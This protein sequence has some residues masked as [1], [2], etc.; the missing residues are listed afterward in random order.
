MRTV[1]FVSLMC[2]ALTGARAGEESVTFSEQNYTNGAAVESYLGSAFSITFDKGSNSNAPKYYDL[3]SAIRCYGGNTFTVTSN[4]TITDITLTFG[5]GDGTN[6]ITTDVGTYD[7]GSWTGSATEVTFT[8]GGTR[9][10]RRIASVTVTYNTSSSTPE[11]VAKPTFTPA[12]GTYLEAQSVT[13]GCMTN[14]ATIY[15]TLDGSDPTT[16]SNVYSNAIP[17]SKTTI[18]KAIAVK[19]G[20]DNSSVASGEYIIRSLGH[21]GTKSNPYTVADARIAIDANTGLTN[22]YATGIISQ[23][24]TYNSSYNSITYWISDDGTTANQLQVYSGKGLDNTNFTSKDEIEVGATV[25]VYGT[26]KKYGSTYEFEQNNYLTSYKAPAG[27]DDDPFVNDDPNAEIGD[28]VLSA[29]IVD[30]VRQVPT[31]GT[32]GFT[33]NTVGY[34]YH[35][36]S[37]KFFAESSIGTQASI[38]ETGILVKFTESSTAYLLNSYSQNSSDGA[39][40][41]HAYYASETALTLDGKNP[42]HRRFAIV[43]NGNGTF[44]LTPWASDSEYDI[45]SGSFFV[46]LAKSNSSSNTALSPFLLPDEGDV[47]W[48][49]VTKAQYKSYVLSLELYNKAQ[50]LKALIDQIE[51]LN[52]DASSVKNVYL[53]ADA[54]K[55]EIEEAIT[56][57]EALYQLAIKNKP[58]YVQPLLEEA[59]SEMQAYS[60][61]LMGKTEFA[62][63]T[64]ALADAQ[65][66]IDSQIGV[67][68]TEALNN[69]NS[70]K[71]TVVA[72]VNQFQSEGVETSLAN[73][74]NVLSTAPANSTV[75]PSDVSGVYNGISYIAEQANGRNEPSYNTEGGDLRIYANGAFTITSNAGNISSVVFNLSY[76]GVR[77]LAAITA[78]TGTVSKQAAGDQTVTWT[79]NATSITFTVSD[80]AEFGTDGSERAGQFDFTDFIVTTVGLAKYYVVTK[81]SITALVES[82]EG[83]TGY[84]TSE[85]SQ[86]KA[87][88]STAANDYYT[89][90]AAYQKLETAVGKLQQLVSEKASQTTIEAAQELMNRAVEGYNSCTLN[91]QEANELTTS[92]DNQKSTLQSSIEKYTNL[93]TALEQLRSE[94]DE[95]N[96]V[97]TAVREASHTLYD[98]TSQAYEDGS[99]IDSQ[100]DAKIVELNNSYNMLH[101]YANYYQRLDQAISSLEAVVT[102]KAMQSL[103]DEATTVISEARVG[104]EQGSILLDEINSSVEIMNTL[105]DDIFTSATQYANLATAITKLQN[106]INEVSG[107]TAHVSQSAVTRANLRLTQTTNQYEAGTITDD[108]IPAR[109]TTIDEMC[110]TLTRSVRL[111]NQFNEALAALKAE[112]DKEQKLSAATYSAAETLYNVNNRAYEEG[113][114]EDDNI[115]EVVGQM[116]DAVTSLQNSSALY[117]QL[118]G[119]IPA[120]QTAVTKKA[121]QTL[122]DEANDLLTTTQGDYAVGTINDED[123]AERISGM[124]A[125]ENSIDASATQYA[126][127]A[128]AITKLQDAINEVSGETAHVSQSALTRANLRLTQTTNQYE[129]GTITDDDIPARITTIDEMCETL[130]RSVRLYNQFNEALAALKAELDKEQKLSAATYSSAEALYKANNT[131]YDEGSIEDDNIEEEVGK[132]QDAVTSLQNSA[133]LYTQLVEAIP[134]LQTAVTKKAMQTLLNEANDLLTTTQGDYAV[135]TINDEEIAE[136]IS[137][138]EVIESSIDVSATHY[139]NLATAITLLQEAVEEVSG[140]TAHVSQS[141]LTRANMRLT[142]TT[143]QY[144]AGSIADEDIP[145]RITTIDDLCET[146]TRSVRLY[147]QFNE[148]LAALKAEL[149]KEQKLSAAT[150]SAAETLFNDNNT[151]YEEGSKDDD[152]IPDAISLLNAAVTNLQNSTTLY[153]QLNA[154]IPALEEAVQKKAVQSLMNEAQELLTEV[155]VGYTDATIT[156]ADVPTYINRM[157]TIETSIAASSEAYKNLNSAIVA[158]ETAVSTAEGN[159]TSNMYDAASSMLTE[160]QNKYEQGTIADADIP[161]KVTGLSNAA[162][163]IIAAKDMNAKVQTCTE[164]LTELNNAIGEAEELLTQAKNDVMACYIESAK[165]IEI[166]A[167]LES[168]TSDLSTLMSERDNITTRLATDKQVH[169]TAEGDMTISYAT[170]LQA[171]NTDLSD[172]RL[173]MDEKLSELNSMI[174]YLNREPLASITTSSNIV[175]LKGEYGTFCSVI[176]LDFTDVEGLQ[177][178]IVTAYIPAEGKIILT[179]VYNVPAGTGLV[180]HGTPNGRY[181]IPEGDGSAVL[182][183][184]LVGTKRSKVLSVEEDEKTNCILADGSYGL[185]FYPTSGGI[186]AAGKAYLPL[187]TSAIYQQNGVKCF[188]LVFDNATDIRDVMNTGQQ[189]VW[190]TIDGKILQQ[191]PRTKGIYVNNGKQV[192]IK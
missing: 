189:D 27:E 38:S 188:T 124:E 18:V 158:M 69:L 57:A 28:V 126:I 55:T 25:V 61:S 98:E 9:N 170:A 72:S 171:S 106:A 123:I 99:I 166:E 62:A 107:E 4:Y 29:P 12:S 53:N 180:V 168:Y 190:Y 60:T 143:N 70:V 73:L 41:Y 42:A 185:G 35:V 34:L 104:Y 1:L 91:N 11:V 120:L 160:A 142:Q 89:S 77:R 68:M 46:G 30:D 136:R 157:E 179:R 58:E 134:A 119:A 122:L 130:T 82:I 178:Y 103:I 22:V 101:N 17:V 148:A 140:E 145:A 159:V 109:I 79:G 10:N 118:A 165:K 5:T 40:W 151:A 85:I 169:A 23:V 15:Y 2:T 183:N 141:A 26:L 161:A 138:M 150:Y 7:S 152:D 19:S 3:G 108:D 115:E 153:A 111:Y 167:N 172:I 97:A 95:N 33:A 66:A 88:I 100:V 121:M 84:E 76:Q 149:D 176:D 52:G 43:N 127:L 20:M 47:D 191:K 154:A 128:T 50:E 116:Q 184:L 175:E 39:G 16:S 146:L 44:R 6:E 186:L 24:D 74:K 94:L 177:A 131:A 54:N 162:A 173:E 8:I 71:E 182:S 45:Y 67:T 164:Q 14:G 163:N 96:K 155:Q 174:E 31:I 117:T 92:L 65:A 112:L 63:L 187:P 125:I 75:V 81:T 48:A 78:T 21:D 139:A 192:L 156:D 181:E 87:D 113:S 133:A 80:N 129:A 110:E 37:G 32:T 135:G 86:L 144:E 102:Q 51:E 13:I 59:M 114:I 36:G 90:V 49:M 83:N 56:E 132:L 105:E 93:A 147:N 64:Q 137:D